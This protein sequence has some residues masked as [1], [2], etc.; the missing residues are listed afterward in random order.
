MSKLDEAPL[1]LRVAIMEFWPLQEWDNAAAISE[2]ES[3]WNP[4]AEN[5]TTRPDAPCG[6]PIDLRGDVIITAEHSIGCF[7][8]NV[9]NIPSDWDARYLFNTRHNAGTAHMMWSERGW[10]PWYF[11]ARKL[12]LL[13]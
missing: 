10:Q 6:T 3:A 5:D 4:F 9:C 1:E 11:S 7:Q 2:L 8:I 13:K 12:G